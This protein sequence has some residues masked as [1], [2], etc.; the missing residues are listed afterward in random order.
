MLERAST[1]LETGGRQLLRAPRPCLRSR[2][3]L[4]STFWHHGASDLNLP[5]WW[6]ASSTVDARTGDV[7]DRMAKTASL[8]ASGSYDGALLE[9]LYSDKTLALL[10]SLYTTGLDASAS[11]RRQLNRPSKRHFTTAQWQPPHDESG[12]DEAIVRQAKE[13][14]AVLLKDSWPIKEL[15]K[16][17]RRKEVGKQELAWQLYTTIPETHLA[18]G[19][20][21]SLREDLLEYLTIDDTPVVPSRILQLFGALPKSKRRPSSYRAAIIAY[22]SLRMVGPAL[23]LLEW[24]RTDRY[25]DLLT[26]GTDIVLQRTILDEQWDLSLRVFKLF[27]RQR[28]IIERQPT[29]TSQWRGQLPTATSIRRGNLLP[30][31][32]RGVTTLPE[33]PSYLQSFL[34]HVR[35]FQYE[36]RSSTENEEAL[37]LFLISFVPHVM[38][39]VLHN[40][41]LDEEFTSYLRQLFDDLHALNLETNACYEHAIQRLLEIPHKRPGSNVE[42][43][44]ASFY[45]QHRQR[46]LDSQ[47]T[48]TPTK[49]SLNLLKSLIMYYGGLT[50]L[51]K[52]QGLIDDLRVFYPDQPVKHSLLRYLIHLYAE[53]G[54]ITRVEAYMEEFKMHNPKFM[55]IKILSAL[56]FA[57]AR[58]ADVEGAITQFNRIRDQYE[59]V[60]DTACWNILLLAYVRADDLDGA[61]ECFNTCL[62]S[63]IMP[64]KYTFGTLLDL[65]AERGD[66]EAFEALFSRALEMGIPLS[67]DVRARSGYVQVFLNAGDP[68]GAKEIAQ[69]ML[70]SWQAGTLQ[71]HAL[72]FTWNLLIQHHALNRDLTGARQHF[73]EMIDNN[74]P[75]DSWTYGSLM[76]ALVEVNKSNAAYRI[77]RKT[78]P[79]SNLPVHA[80][81]YAIVMTGL[82]REGGEQLSLAMGA[83]ERMME[84][85]V[86]QTE[87]S[88]EASIRTLGTFE[89]QK[90]KKQRAKHPNYRLKQVE[91]AVENMLVEAVQGQ[92]AHRQP[93]HKKYVDSRNFGATP[94]SHYGLLIS[95]YS[96]RGAYKICKKLF[97]KAEA[98]TPDVDNYAVPMTLITGSM[99]AHLKAGEHAEV[100]KCW[101]LARS[102]A[103]KLS[104]TFDQLLHPNPPPPQTDSLLDPRIRERFEDS[105]ISANRRHILFKAARIYI[106]SLLDP[107]NPNPDT[108]RK[109]QRTLRDLLSDGY[110]ID[111]FTWNEFIVALAQRGRLVDAFALCEEFLMPSFPGWRNL[112][113][114]YVRKNRQGYQWM[115][116]R[117]Y[118]IKKTSI[119]PRYKTL[120][121]LAAE[122][123]RARN[124]ERNG[125]GYDESTG[126]W[127]QELLKEVGPM[128]IRAIETMPRTNDTMQM[129]YFH[130]S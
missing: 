18:R 49:P 120:I 113:P 66:V 106:R 3:T 116:L 86:P 119:I 76:R 92:V 11:R 20:H 19:G 103:S 85:G 60:P 73:R 37:S 123:R 51:T 96:D 48:S 109:A 12:V 130:N 33:L 100:A 17:L 84:Q 90:L 87:S 45:N 79:K 42:S 28:P 89:L 58:R 101:E 4:H 118:E 127:E 124:D 68:E 91:E 23:K 38:D 1:C 69:G 32:W 8:T 128:V 63:D 6:A 54:D 105:Q 21:W 129:K 122:F 75:L 125:L 47:D 41:K 39:Q 35:E 46:C 67:Q 34:N 97:K 55:D 102:S 53:N 93:R 121:I 88:Q 114:N 83:Y 72:T 5:T 22:I 110:T 14:M 65:C 30:E 59:L 126:R 111:V 94:Q 78:M 108:L 56:P 104:K 112:C 31:I 98:A 36:L 74:I 50:D 82:L 25:F 9:F 64:D 44:C 71:G 29:A 10:R 43:L 62:D 99:E 2:R 16:L 15:P 70:K 61:L 40:R 27:L 95:L 7:D 115:E 13:E 80:L 81:H 57:F 117:H 26:I 52:V 107:A 77:L 24:I